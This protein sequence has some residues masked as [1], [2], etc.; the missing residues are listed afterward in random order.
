MRG[1]CAILV[2]IAGT[3]IALQATANE[4][5]E[6]TARDIVQSCNFKYPGDDQK[7][8][9]TIVLRDK[10]GN[11]KR[12]VYSRFWKDYRGQDGIADKMVL[13]TEFPPDAKGA[14]FMRWGYTPASG[15]NAEQ[16]VYLP[17]LKRMRR[18]SVRDPGESFLGSDLTHADI[19]GREL[20]A[21]EH[22]LLQTT[23]RDGEDLFVVESVPRDP[24]K[25]LYSKVISVFAK[26]AEDESCVKRGMEYYDPRGNLLKEQTIS[27]QR[28]DNAWAWDEVTV[29]NLQTGHSSVFRVS[30]VEI[31]VGLNENIFTERNLTKGP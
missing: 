27:W 3:G 20:D 5:G 25:A 31:N 18:V 7:T 8:R 24:S 9:L 16:W 19:G 12:N 15:K 2:L 4:A 26:G 17:V 6:I 29:R 14:G 28:V 21:D 13:F 22:T 10:D 11:E 30:D 23:Q 1:T